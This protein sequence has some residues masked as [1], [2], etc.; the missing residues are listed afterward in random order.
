MG[1][2]SLRCANVQK[3]EHYYNALDKQELWTALKVYLAGMPGSK[4]GHCLT[5][6]RST[7][8]EVSHKIEKNR[9]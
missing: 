8:E 1:G 3:G 2:R 5:G 4:E 6:F 9:I 7:L